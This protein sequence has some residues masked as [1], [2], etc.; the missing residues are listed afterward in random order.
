MSVARLRDIPGFS[1]DRV[2]AAAGDDPAVLRLENLDT[3]IV[4][5]A[6]AIAAT[7]EAV[8]TDEANSWLPFS[9][10]DDLKQQEPS[11]VREHPPGVEKHQ[12]VDREDVD[13]GREQRQL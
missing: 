8:G 7:R 10:R 11:P 12:P 4:P 5:P 3:D 13:D 9:G 2:A 6:A 1:I